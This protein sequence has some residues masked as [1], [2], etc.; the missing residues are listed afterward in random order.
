MENEEFHDSFDIPPETA[1]PGTS[2]GNSASQSSTPLVPTREAHGLQDKIAALTAA[3]SQ[4]LWHSQAARVEAVPTEHVGAWEPSVMIKDLRTDP[5][6]TTRVSAKINCLGLFSSDSEDEGGVSTKRSSRGKKLKSG[7]TAK[8]TIHVVTPQLWPTSFLS[9]AYVSKDRNYDE[10]T[11]AEFAAGYASI[12]QLNSLSSNERPGRLNHFVVLMYFVTQ[13]TW[14][15][16]RE[17]HAAIF[18]FLLTVVVL[19]GAF[20]LLTWN[21]DFSAPRLNLRNDM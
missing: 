16:V 5:A 10:L 3:I 20:H 7:K 4:A 18:F 2:H 15:A 17:F 11:L 12:L 9:L 21:L 1:P 8:L 19:A 13:F 6:L 14:P